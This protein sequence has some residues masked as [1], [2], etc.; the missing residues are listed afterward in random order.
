M[1][2]S[3]TR[4]TL[5]RLRPIAYYV[6]LHYQPDIWSNGMPAKVYTFRCL[7]TL[8]YV[9]FTVDLIEVNSPLPQMDR[10]VRYKLRGLLH[11]NLEKQTGRKIPAFD[12][13]IISDRLW[14]GAQR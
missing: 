11:D 5:S 14:E 8:G 4:G 13:T 7:G 6:A 9:N 3:G 1:M 2:A 12:H 10:D